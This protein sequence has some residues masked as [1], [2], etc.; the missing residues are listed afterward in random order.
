MEI[1]M[2]VKEEFVYKTRGVSIGT[3]F[4]VEN[5]AMDKEEA[6][7]SKIIAVGEL[8]GDHVG[9]DLGLLVEEKPYTISFFTDQTEKLFS[10]IRKALEMKN[11]EEAM[12]ILKLHVTTKQYGL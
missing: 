1:K 10:R 4:I 3:T 8:R 2:T 9:I 12:K 7:A 6:Y 11:S 5:L